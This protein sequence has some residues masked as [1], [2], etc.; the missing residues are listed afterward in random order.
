MNV[1]GSLDGLLLWHISERNLYP[2]E[3]P[4]TTVE[5][6]MHPLASGY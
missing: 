6:A 3:W 2:R 5:A 4:A 1:Y